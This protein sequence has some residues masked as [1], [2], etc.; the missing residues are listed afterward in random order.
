MARV[1]KKKREIG[2][3]SAGLAFKQG[4]QPN[5]SRVERRMIIEQVAMSCLA[6][7]LLFAII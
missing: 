4:Y 5:Y 3:D 6:V 2:V 7:C 1:C